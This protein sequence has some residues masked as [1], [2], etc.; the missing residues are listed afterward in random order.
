VGQLVE[1]PFRGTGWVFL[2]EL[3][4]RRGI[5][6]GS[7]RLDPEGQSFIFRAEEPGDYVLKF[8]KQ[9]FIRDF[10][11]NDYVRVIIAEPPASGGTAVNPPVDR[12]RVIAEPRWPF[13]PG[14]APASGDRDAELSIGTGVPP[15]DNPSPELRPP[16]P[17][18]GPD[19]VPE[20]E[21]PSAP[22]ALPPAA[23]TRPPEAGSSPD[24]Y[25]SR[26]REEYDAGRI[27]S[28]LSILDQFREKYPAGSDEAWWLYGQLLEANGPR[29]DIRSALDYY[30][31]LIREYPQSTRFD[32]A[33][34]RI[35]YL[36]RYYFNIQ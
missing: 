15:E 34:R 26:A 33:R 14:E 36:E 31:R 29:R 2:G 16:E 4:A 8:Y 1:I 24:E 11:L 18:R 27:V 17:V 20:R 12:G 30:R 5:A 10:I 22:A 19:T 3:G 35:A 25:I 6:Y 13:L 32:E 21:A 7:R 9:D 23:E 28:A